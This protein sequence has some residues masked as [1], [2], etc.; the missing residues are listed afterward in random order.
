[1][2][3]IIS[4]AIGIMFAAGLYLMMRRRLAQLIIGL[5]LLTNAA[6]LLVFTVAG[7]SRDG[8][9][10]IGAG[11]DQLAATAADPLPQALVLTAIVIGFAV[12]AFFIALSY[13]TFRSM[14]TDDIGALTNTDRISVV[15]NVAPAEPASNAR[16]AR[17]AGH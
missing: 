14:G 2:E 16:S 15:R 9:P 1:M 4:I 7:L 8:A 17:T 6:N 3:I 10:I 13:R 12:L 11:S 5:G